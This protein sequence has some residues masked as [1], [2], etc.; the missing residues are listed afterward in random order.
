MKNIN[1]VRG[2]LKAFE[3]MSKKE[4][5][6]E[7]R[8]RRLANPITARWG[9]KKKEEGETKDKKKEEGDFIPDGRT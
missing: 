1:R 9:F 7:M 4:I 2:A 8:R 3:G 6:E 5:S